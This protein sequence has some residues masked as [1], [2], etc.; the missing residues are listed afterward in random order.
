MHYPSTQA[1]AEAQ[2]TK[3]N[4]NNHNTLHENIKTMRNLS[5]VI[6]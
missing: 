1:Y 6:T 4:D 5:T 2:N 3:D